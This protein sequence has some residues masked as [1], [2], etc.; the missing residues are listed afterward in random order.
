MQCYSFGQ[1][2]LLFLQKASFTLNC[3]SSL[4]VQISK[5]PD[6]RAVLAFL[7]VSATFIYK[8]HRFH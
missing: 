2:L 6:I 7:S 3:N 4:P 1:F 5:K 8:V